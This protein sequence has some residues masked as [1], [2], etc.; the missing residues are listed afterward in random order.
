MQRTIWSVIAP[1]SLTVFYTLKCHFA[2]GSLSVE[3][4]SEYHYA[5]HLRRMTCRTL[6]PLVIPGRSLG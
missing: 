5:P 1:I 3:P 4:L 6:V 2:G